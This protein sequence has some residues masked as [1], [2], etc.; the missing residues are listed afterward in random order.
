[1]KHNQRAHKN[2]RAHKSATQLNEESFREL[3][4][5]LDVGLAYLSRRGKVLYSN[6]RFAA[7]VGYH[8]HTPLKGK[9][10]TAIVSAASWPTLNEAL[11]HATHRSVE[12]ELRIALENKVRVVRITLAPGK[13]FAAE[14][15]ISV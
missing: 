10:F 4:D 14:D 12:G 11:L 8:P 6:P 5:G 1:M 9:H 7:L 15:A 2:G 13:D 3:V